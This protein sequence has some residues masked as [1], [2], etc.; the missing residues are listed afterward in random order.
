MLVSCVP[1][2]KTCQIYASYDQDAEPKIRAFAWVAHKHYSANWQSQQLYYWPQPKQNK[3]Q[4]KQER[5]GRR[6][7]SNLRRAV[8]HKQM[9]NRDNGKCGGWWQENRSGREFFQKHFIYL[10]QIV[11]EHLAPFQCLDAMWQ[12]PPGNRDISISSL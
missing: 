4:E 1:P 8:A 9:D 11:S 5:Q 7:D 2:N 12:V 10:A 3:R 6:F